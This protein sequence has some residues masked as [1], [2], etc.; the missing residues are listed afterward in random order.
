M[1]LKKGEGVIGTTYS[2][3]R[4]RLVTV[5]ALNKGVKYD[6][7][8]YISSHSLKSFVLLLLIN[9]SSSLIWFIFILS[10]VLE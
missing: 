7:G 8:F 3:F 9:I 5:Y 6:P 4:F 2:L 1:T 10:L